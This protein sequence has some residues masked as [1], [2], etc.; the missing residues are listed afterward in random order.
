MK[1]TFKFTN[2]R[3]LEFETFALKEANYRKV[4][5]HNNGEDS[6]G[7]WACFSDEGIKAYTNDTLP[8]NEHT[9][10]AILVNSALF[11]YPRNSWG[12][13]I[14]VKMMG[15]NRPEC[16]I[17]DLD[18]AMIFCQERLDAD[19]KKAKS[20]GKLSKNQTKNGRKTTKTHSK[21]V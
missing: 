12:L 15:P 8:S 5:I 16:N 11:F 2:S 7:I 3:I 4:R 9:F 10:P 19:A 13:Y 14:P 21:S 17:A 1:Q 18:G 20:K 6:E